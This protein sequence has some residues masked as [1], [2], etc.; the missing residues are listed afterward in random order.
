MAIIIFMANDFVGPQNACIGLAQSLRQ[1]GHRTYFC[2]RKEFFP[3]FLSNGF[4]E[5]DLLELKLATS[6][7]TAAQNNDNKKSLEYL[8]EKIREFGFVTDLTPLEKVRRIKQVNLVRTTFEEP[9]E[10]LDGQLKNYL[11][12][13][14][15]DL[16]IYDGEVIPPAILY[17]PNCPWIYLFCSNPIGLFDSDR[18]PPFLSDFHTL[19][20]VNHDG[21]DQQPKCWQEFRSIL[22]ECYYSLV[23][24][25]QSRLCRKLSYPD[26]NDNGWM[27]K[28]RFFIQSPYLNLYQYPRE[29]DYIDCIDISIERYCRV[30]SFCRHSKFFNDDNNDD[31]EQQ[32]LLLEKIT[33]KQQQNGSGKLIYLSLGSMGSCNLD[34]M[35]RLIG[36]LSKTKHTYLISTGM[37]NDQLKLDSNM[38]GQSYLPQIW[39]F[40]KL[41]IDLAII[42]GGNNSLC[43]TFEYG[44]PCLIMPLFYDQFLNARRVEEKQLGRSIDP[45]NFDDNQL[46][47]LIDQMLN[48]DRLNKKMKIISQRIQQEDSKSK[49]CKRLEEII[50]RF[51]QNNSNNK[52]SIV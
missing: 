11:E 40:S 13:I 41:N 25:A 4:D 51:K 2:L 6:T 19:K 32:R 35:Q 17:W 31:S 12:Q 22:D 38:F 18:L 39:L 48:D 26:P 47:N 16:I 9:L 8:I 27:K 5:Q 24:Q 37:V 42:H 15:P 21:D 28:Y 46:I 36:I 14:H 1:H 30:D 52:K 45:F 43:E 44:I 20:N 3:R 50:E 23:R 10:Q 29:L 49:C 7:T 34:L 33:K